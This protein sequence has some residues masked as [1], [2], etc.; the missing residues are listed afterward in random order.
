M[1]TQP[2]YLPNGDRVPGVTT[3]LGKFTDPGALMYWSYK[4]G[5]THERQLIE[6]GNAPT[7]FKGVSDS[8][9]QVGTIAHAAVEAYIKGG[10]GVDVIKES[11]LDTGQRALAETAYQSYL[12]W[13]KQTRIE[14]IEQELFLVSEE[15]RY[16]GT[17][18]AIGMVTGNLCVLDWKTSNGVYDNH[19]CQLA[20]Y[21]KLYE[22]VNNKKIEGGGHICR[23]GK[24]RGDF[25]HHFYPREMLD[26]YWEVFSNLRRCYEILHNA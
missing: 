15:H 4:I 14:I 7:T 17:P 3:I 20:A 2:Y 13:E 22:E 12:T 5:R 9:A 18:D 1:P 6:T 21:V 16:G 10:S 19:I 8:A 23:F 26:S 25:A 11:D 24:Q